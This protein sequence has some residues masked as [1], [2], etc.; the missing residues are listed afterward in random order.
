MT[1]RR[2]DVGAP[3]AMTT[4][5]AAVGERRLAERL[6]LT[7][8]RLRQCANPMLD[9]ALPWP[10]AALADI[11]CAE[12]GAGTPLFDDYRRRLIAAGALRASR[13]ER[14]LIAGIRAAIAALAAALAA[15]GVEGDAV[16]V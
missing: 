6:G 11:A 7:P 5:L 8:S 4:A 3:A 10:R 15:A 1:Y 16:A 14:R 12:A 9:Q 2:A 13:G